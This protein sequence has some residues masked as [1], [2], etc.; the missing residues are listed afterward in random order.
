MWQ[1]GELNS[2]C[3][4]T[5][6]VATAMKELCAPMDGYGYFYNC[7][8]GAQSREI[9]QAARFRGIYVHPWTVN[10]LEVFESEYFDNYHGITT[11]HADF[12]KD[13]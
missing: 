6:D 13:Y 4:A 3:S 2:V 9:L 5:D 7:N 11:D 10:S 1:W 12:A 8:Y